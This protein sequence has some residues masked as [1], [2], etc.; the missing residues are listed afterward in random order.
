MIS[1]SKVP[2]VCRFSEVTEEHHHMCGSLMCKFSESPKAGS[3]VSQC[4]LT[5]RILLLEGN[6]VLYVPNI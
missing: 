1:E 3:N 4:I 6:E 5:S 2:G